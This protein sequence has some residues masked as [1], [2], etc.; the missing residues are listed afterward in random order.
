MDKV[1]NRNSLKLYIILFS[2]L[3]AIIVTVLALYD[4]IDRKE[5][6]FESAS[7]AMGTY[8]QQTVYGKNAENAANAAMVD[9]NNFEKLISWRID[10]SEI[11]KINAN[12]GKDWIDLSDRTMDLL[13]K[14]IDVSKRSDGAYDLTILPISR[15]WDFGGEN[16]RVPSITEIESNLPLV[17]YSNLRVNEDVKRAKLTEENSGVDLGSSGKGAACDVA[18]E[19]YKNNGA[20]YGIIAV[21]GSVGVYGTKSNKTP[22]KIAIRDPF[23]GME[24][25][26]GMAVVKIKDGFI[27]TSGSYEKNFEKDG[28]TYHHII[29]PK[30]GYPVETDLVSVS[31]LHSNGAIS[32]L[33]ST[34]CYVLGREESTQLLEYYGAQAIFIDKYKNV[35]ATEGIRNDVIITN[36]EFNL[37]DW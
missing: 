7:T 23:K 13:I 37:V 18:I 35:F 26:D 31:V 12:S 27:S 1:E 10:S 16:Q 25:S 36:E 21:G 6:S 2:I 24:Q 14:G 5:K 9:I 15:L 32:D 17:D 30:T 3:V 22:W 29:D 11:A 4:R 20:E 28:I 19:A 34:A 33:L 8:V